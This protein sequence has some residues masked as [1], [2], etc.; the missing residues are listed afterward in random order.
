MAKKTAL[1]GAHIILTH[2]HTHTH[3]QLLTHT[4]CVSARGSVG[5]ENGC[6]PWAFF[7]V[8]TLLTANANNLISVISN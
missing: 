5:S 1:G 2:A 8:F 6:V 4:T 3:A 7:V